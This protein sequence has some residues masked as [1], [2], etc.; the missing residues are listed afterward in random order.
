MAVADS[1]LSAYLCIGICPTLAS[2]NALSICTGQLNMFFVF[3]TPLATPEVASFSLTALAPSCF[4]LLQSD[5]TCRITD[6]SLLPAAREGR[7]AMAEPDEFMAAILQAGPIEH[8]EDRPGLFAAIAAHRWPDH[9]AAVQFLVRG[10]QASM[11]RSCRERRYMQ[12]R[13][14]EST[15]LLAGLVGR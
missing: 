8:V 15:G 10:I 5:D 3:A 6:L 4:K 1:L 14:R 11:L 13:A 12:R 9:C 7:A 2:P